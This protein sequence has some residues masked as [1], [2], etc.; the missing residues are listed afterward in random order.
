MEVIEYRKTDNGTVV[1]GNRQIDLGHKPSTAID[2][3][4]EF[5]RDVPLWGGREWKTLDVDE[6]ETV[7]REAAVCI[8]EMHQQQR[9]IAVKEHLER[10]GIIRWWKELR[11]WKTPYVPSQDEILQAMAARCTQLSEWMLSMSRRSFYADSDMSYL[12]RKP[13]E[14]AERLNPS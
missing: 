13:K 6:I 11:G 1:V 3:F 10:N 8:R 9:D 12:I 5:F 2:R 4:H 14:V 7:F